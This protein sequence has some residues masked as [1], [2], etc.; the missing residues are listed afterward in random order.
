MARMSSQAPQAQWRTLQRRTAQAIADVDARGVAAMGAERGAT[1]T[2]D[3]V[4]DI[5]LLVIA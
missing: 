1:G 5:A 3:V 2:R 4:T